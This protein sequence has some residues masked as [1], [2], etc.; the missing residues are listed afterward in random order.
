MLFLHCWLEQDKT[1]RRVL[2]VGTD[3]ILVADDLLVIFVKV[4]PEK[5]KLKI[6]FAGKR[7]M[8]F[9]AVT[10]SDT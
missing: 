2:L 5:G 1:V 10:P 8:A 4:I 9:A 7:T 3:F 6:S